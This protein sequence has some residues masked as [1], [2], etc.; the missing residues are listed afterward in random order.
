MKKTLSESIEWADN[1][2]PLWVVYTNAETGEVVA[3]LIVPVTK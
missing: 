2:M 3:R 1:K